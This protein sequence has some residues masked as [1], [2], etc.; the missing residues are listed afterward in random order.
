V[1]LSVLLVSLVLPFFGWWWLL[2]AVPAGLLSVHQA[3]HQLP[4]VAGLNVAAKCNKCGKTLSLPKELVLH[5]LDDAADL[6]DDVYVTDVELECPH[7]NHRFR[8]KCSQQGVP[9]AR[10]L[11]I[12]LAIAVGI[13][14][15]AVFLATRSPW[16]LVVSIPAGLY[17]L[18]MLRNISR[19]WLYLEVLVRCPECAKL[20]VVSRKKLLEGCATS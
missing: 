10:F 18:N 16:W 4:I 8:P 15:L 1:F 11:P 12:P 9:S 14:A 6:D 20:F 17:G 13:L 5:G 2:L 3:R 19:K 7:C